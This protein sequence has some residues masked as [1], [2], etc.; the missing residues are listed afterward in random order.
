MAS[1]IVLLGIVPVWTDTPPIMTARSMMATR[2]R[3]FAA[4]MA[5]FWPAGPLPITTRSY[6]DTLILRPSIHNATSIG[7]STLPGYKDSLLFSSFAA[8]AVVRIFRPRYELW[9]ESPLLARPI[10]AA[11][12]AQGNQGVNALSDV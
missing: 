9:R 3:A 6:S 1:R 11:I 5:P 7:S 12:P 8:P 4:A 2:L 10:S